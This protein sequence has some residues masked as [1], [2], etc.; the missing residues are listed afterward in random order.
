MKKTNKLSAFTLIE[1]L[2]VIAVIGILAGMLFPAIKAVMDSAQGT[3]VAN[4]GKQIVTAI[5]QANIDREANSKGPIWP[6]IKDV[7]WGST[8]NEY[9]AR[10]LGEGGKVEISGINVAMFAGGGVP[11]AADPAKLKEGGCIWSVLGGI[12]SCDDNTPFM[13]TRNMDD[14]DE[15]AFNTSQEGDAGEADWSGKLNSTGNNEKPFNKGQVVLARKGASFAVIKA[16]DLTPSSF[17][18]GST[19]EATNLKV[20]LAKSSTEESNSEGF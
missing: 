4:N 5:T 3:R 13:W 14:I 11:A 9:F 18:A 17:L 1:L 10:L 19:N 20:Y 6:G 8:A 15:A 12:D 2:I 7:K 16:K